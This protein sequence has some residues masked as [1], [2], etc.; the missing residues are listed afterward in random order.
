MNSKLFND[1]I[2]LT[3]WNELIEVYK[4]KDLEITC[5]F[6]TA[7]VKYIVIDVIRP[8][9]EAQVDWLRNSVKILRLKV[10]FIR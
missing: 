1:Y 5:M 3:I 6:L 8:N 4:Y 2:N 7:T 9:T 10:Y